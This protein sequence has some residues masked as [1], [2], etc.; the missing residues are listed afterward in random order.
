[1]F[2][3]FKTR[4]AAKTAQAELELHSITLAAKQLSEANVYAQ[5][6]PDE[7]DW[8]TIGT[9]SDGRDLT[10]QQMKTSR[11][12][13]RKFFRFNPHGKSIIRNMC[14]FVIGRGVKFITLD[15]ESG[16]KKKVNKVWARFVEINKWLLRQKEIVT[17][18]FRDGEVFLRYFPLKNKDSGY[19][20]FRFIDPDSIANPPQATM[21][22]DQDNKTKRGTILTYGIEHNVNDVEDIQWYWIDGKEVKAEEIIHIKLLA[23]S[24]QK[25]GVPFME[26]VLEDIKNYRNWLKDRIVLNKIRTA[27]AL[28]RKI[29]A[30]VG[31]PTQIN[32]IRDQ[33]SASIRNVK[34]SKVQAFEPGTILTTRGIEYE[35]LTPNLEAR[36]S[37]QDGRN[38]LLNVAAGVGMPEYM[39]TADSSNANY[40]STMVA[41]SPAVKEFE[42]WQDFFSVFFQTIWKLQ[43]EHAK[44]KGILPASTDTD[45]K[46]EFPTLVMRDLQKE[47]RAYSLMRDKGVI[48]I[49][50]WRGKAGLDDKIENEN[51]ED[52]DTGETKVSKLIP[53]PNK[54]P[55][56]GKEPTKKPDKGDDDDEPT[57]GKDKPAD[58]K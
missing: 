15:T 6:D 11:S 20:A 16:R 23:D 28:I 17:R 4:L 45:C 43:M 50:T 40:S 36:D 52:E 53:D 8:Q 31:T 54:E 1:M 47:A 27:I 22:V 46:V 14:K 13:S 5:P 7:A 32:S 55:A 51:M 44:K 35:Y 39:V 21:Q 34:S 26:S 10:E 38:I 58:N 25:R 18:G 37:A 49:K 41:E 48:S 3:L 30:G 24:D 33:N 12:Q 42:D 2:K 57:G 56:G 19:L 29:P 9:V